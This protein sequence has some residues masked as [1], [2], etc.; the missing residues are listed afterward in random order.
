MTARL[1]AGLAVTVL[2]MGAAA[3]RALWLTRLVWSGVPVP[4][5]RRPNVAG[6]IKAQIVDVFAQRKLLKRPLSG[7]AHAFTFWA[8]V[9]LLLTII[10]AYGALFQ[11]DFAIPGIGHSRALGLIEDFFGRRVGSWLNGYLGFG[12]RRRLTGRSLLG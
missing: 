3:V 11:R 4:P 7:W 9:I 6:A 10:E 8:F 5:E 12:E 2:G 1:I